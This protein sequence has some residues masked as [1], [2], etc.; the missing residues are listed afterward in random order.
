MAPPASSG[1]AGV[2]VKLDDALVDGEVVVHHPLDVEARFHR[3]PHGRA[4]E[5]TQGG[6]R[7][8]RLLL[9]IDEETVLPG[10]DDL[11]HRAASPRND[12]RPTSH[13]L[14]DAEAEWLVEVAEMQQR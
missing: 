12:R 11:R 14:D 9:G 13:R 3:C 10:T 7:L 1:S 2:P 5:V 8:D 6:D 4:V